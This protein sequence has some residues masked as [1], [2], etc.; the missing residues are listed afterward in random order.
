MPQTNDIV[1]S[2]SALNVYNNITNIGD[3]NI[4]CI[5]MENGRIGVNKSS[6]AVEIDVSGEINCTSLKI[7]GNSVNPLGQLYL[8]VT[9]TDII[10]NSDNSLNLGSTTF[11]LN[12]SIYSFSKQ[13]IY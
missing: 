13:S 7:N 3:N 1:T 4:V 9:G 6:P 2:V 5:D 10:P 12:N 11:R 8:K